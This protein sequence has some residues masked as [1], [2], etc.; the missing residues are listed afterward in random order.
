MSRYTDVALLGD[1][2]L[3]CD[4]PKLHLREIGTC[5]LGLAYL[6]QIDQ[7]RLYLP[8]G[9]SSMNAYLIRELHMSDDMAWH[10]IDAARIA[11]KFPAIYDYVADGRLHLTGVRMLSSHL[12]P[13]N[14]DELLKAAVYK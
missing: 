14:C 3:L 12:T 7:R 9:H 8:F 4:F 10:R 5:A 1:G 2:A 13:E 11:R 6:G